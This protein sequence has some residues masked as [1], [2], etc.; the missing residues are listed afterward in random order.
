MTTSL[1][2]MRTMYQHARVTLY[3]FLHAAKEM[4][5]LGKGRILKRHNLTHKVV[6]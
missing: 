6:D 5:G 3:V 1:I 2:T 4:I